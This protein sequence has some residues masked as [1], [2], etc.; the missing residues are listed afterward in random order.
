[1]GGNLAIRTGAS[2]IV[3]IA[4]GA[5][6]RHSDIRCALTGL[7]FGSA[8]RLNCGFELGSPDAVGFEERSGE[9]RTRKGL[10]I[11]LACPALPLNL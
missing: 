9:G 4:A 6:L 1:M 7:S 11:T 2:H 8:K 3:A 5:R 10:V